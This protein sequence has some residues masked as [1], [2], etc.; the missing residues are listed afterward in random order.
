MA[1]KEKGQRDR[2][3]D[4]AAFSGPILLDRDQVVRHVLAKQH[5]TPGATTTDVL[6][7]V[8]DLVGLHGT[9]PTS[10]YLSLYARMPSF[11]R[12]DLERELYERRSLIRLKVMRA[13]VFVLTHAL[14]P[15]AYAAT[16]SLSLGRGQ[17]NLGLD[18]VVFDELAPAVLQSLAGRTLTVSELRKELG[19]DGDLAATVGLLCDQGRLVRDRPTGS[20]RSSVFR[21]RIWRE[22]LPNVDLATYGEEEATRLLVQRYLTTYGPATLTDIAWWTGLGATRV[23]RALQAL[24]NELV[25]VTI[26]GFSGRSHIARGDL[27]TLQAAAPPYDA[28][29][30]LLPE[31]DPLIMG[32]KER[33]RYVAP[34]HRELVFD[35]GG[36]ATSVIL[37]DG[38]VAGVWDVIERPA[39]EVRVL[40][41]DPDQHERE[42]ILDRA[43]ATGAFWLAEPAPVVEYA[44]MIPLTRRTGVMR[45]PLDG[46][47][48]R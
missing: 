17:R 20:W 41:F 42:A 39:P 4:S 12:S 40:L 43:A 46:A 26:D 48:P 28:C 7:V 21:Y 8:D 1:M 36:N 3:A 34:R 44:T 14:A 16:R 23:R 45:D 47:Q 25:E 37:V 29:V 9:S 35:R 15:I 2:E 33:D 24:S 31:L 11:A 6:R 19:R 5:L 38:V 13:T 18:Q 27:A 30:A 32:Y 10:P 22:I